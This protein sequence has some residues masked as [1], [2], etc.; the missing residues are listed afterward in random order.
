MT[1]YFRRHLGAKLLL[2]YLAIIVVGVVVLIAASQF[3]LPASFNQHMGG[4]MGIS[5][6]GM[7]MGGQGFGEPATMAQLYVDF[8]DSFN[9][10]LTYAALAA[11]LVAAALSLFFSRS[12]VAPV[13]AMSLAT[14]RIADGRYDERVQV[15]GA[16][17]LAQLAMR[18]NQMAEK[19]N[20]VESM[21][22]RL[23]GDVSHE[24]R[25]PLTAIKGSMEGLMDGV[26]PATNETYQ[27]IHAEADRIN[28]LVDDLQELSRVE[29]R[30]YQ[31]DIRPLDI[32]S[33]VKTVT[34]RLAPQAES[35]RITL[36][37]ELAPDLPRILADED[38]AVQVLTNLV[39][40]A[41]QYT[42]EGGVVTV[43]A[44]RAKD[45]LQISIRDTGIGI[46]PEHLDHIFDRFYRVDASRSRSRQ[47]GGGSGIGLTIARALVEAHG[48]H[49][50]VESEGEGQGSAF[51]FTLPIAK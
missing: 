11:M 22:R 21:R 13:R 32:S 2:S 16:D 51:A 20:Q 14:Q 42:P 35:K 1:D 7:G 43:S 41:L 31:L 49:I 19:L 39:G 37:V 29:A 9:E 24:L 46:P 33:C 5:N 36:D 34:K 15:K 48:G 26:L 17:E 47:A 28:R 3:V 45:N 8:R 4:M 23:I 12:V 10:A 50:W 44:M 27:Q 38:R 6:N 18:F 25:T 30:A 40:N